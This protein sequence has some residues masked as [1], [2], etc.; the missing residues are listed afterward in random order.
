MFRTAKPCGRTKH[1]LGCCSKFKLT[2]DQMYQPKERR[3]E[4][5]LCTG[6]KICDKLGVKQR[7]TVFRAAN[8]GPLCMNFPSENGIAKA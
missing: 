1:F 3:G 7:L 5:P 8:F 2:C 4:K 6:I